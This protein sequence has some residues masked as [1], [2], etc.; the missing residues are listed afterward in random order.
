MSIT[1]ETATVQD[2]LDAVKAQ[3]DR[4]GADFVYQ[5]HTDEATGIEYCLYVSDGKCDCIVGHVLHGWGVSIEALSEF[6]GYGHLSGDN[7]MFVGK[8][9]GANP[10]VST[11]LNLVQMNQDDGRTW[12]QCYEYALYYVTERG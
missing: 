6:D 12:G 10:F 4:A 2:V 11:L 3:V 7:A 1:V 8:K 9:L 5:S